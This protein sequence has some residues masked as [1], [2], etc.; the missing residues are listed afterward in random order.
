MTYVSCIDKQIFYFLSHQGNPVRR[1]RRYKIL[2][3]KVES[4]YKDLIY[5]Q[6]ETNRESPLERK[7]STVSYASYKTYLTS[8]VFFVFL[9][10]NW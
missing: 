2:S 8:V 3:V 9:I 10:L 1:N 6:E 5:E 7:S 4:K